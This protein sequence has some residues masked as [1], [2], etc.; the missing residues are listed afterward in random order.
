VNGRPTSRGPRP[1]AWIDGAIVP[2]ARARVSVF[3]RGFLYGDAFFETLRVKDGR[4]VLWRPHLRRLRASLAA[5]GIDPPGPGLEEAARA[6][7]AAAGLREGAL[8]LVVTRGTGEGLLPPPGLRPTVVMTLRPLPAGLARA[9]A[10][11]IAAVR[12]R[13]GRGLARADA[14]HKSIAYLGSI[15]GRREAARAGADDALFVESDGRVSEATAG[16]LLVVRRGRLRTPPPSSGCLPGVTRAVA[17]SLAR[18]AGLD[19]RE[20]PI[21]AADLGRADEIL[22]TGSVV[23]ILPVVRLDGRPVGDGRPGPVAARLA[24]AWHAHVARSLAADTRRE[25]RAA[26]GRSAVRGRSRV[27]SHRARW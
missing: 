18:R 17:L 5:F 8:R 20:E 13:F 7:L 9:E 2:A 3:D 27:G 10:S 19:V 22:V 15:A 14:G 26:A 1:L 21:R 4:L 12:L 23:G 25:T 11:G 6:L 16:N 24:A